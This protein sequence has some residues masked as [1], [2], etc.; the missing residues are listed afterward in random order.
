MTMPD[1]QERCR[2]VLVAPEID[3]LEA[4]AESLADALS[5]GDVASVILVAQDVEERRLQRRIE[6][7]AETCHARDVALVVAG[8]ARLALRAG[9]D[10][11]HFEG[12]AAELAD[13]V[14][15]LDGKLMVGAGAVRTRHD[16]LE[17]GE[18]RPDYLFFGRF[19]FDDRPDPHPRNL[20]LG[21]WWAQMVEIPCIVQ[22]GSDLNSVTAVAATGAEFVALSSAIFGAD[23]TPGE[24]VAEANALLD[25]PIPRK[26]GVS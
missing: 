12:P 6:R 7:L 20:A 16:A 10:G 18:A 1:P 9:A 17:R 22:G 4:Q 8:E 23:R 13:L 21:E 3:D 2:I 24:C 5:G 26:E 14:N 25:A 19:G 11:I 15:S